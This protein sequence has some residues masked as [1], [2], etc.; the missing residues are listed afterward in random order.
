VTVQ[1]TIFTGKAPKIEAVQ[2]TEDNV[3]ELAV[4]IGA[5]TYSVEKTLVGGERKVKFN[6]VKIRE[7]YPNHP[8]VWSILDSN[9]NDGTKIGD[10]IVRIPEGVDWRFRENDIRFF[11]VTQEDIDNFVRQAIHTGEIDPT[12]R[13]DKKE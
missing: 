10:Y 2:I 8:D 4:W 13:A 9:R 1:F 3:E 11:S 5:D 12:S 6:R 7:N